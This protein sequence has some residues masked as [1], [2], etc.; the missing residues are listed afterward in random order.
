MIALLCASIAFVQS[1]SVPEDF[2]HLDIY[3]QD[4]RYQA[5]T[6]RLYAIAIAGDPHCANLV[7]PESVQNIAQKCDTFI[8]LG[9]R[10]TDALA[11]SKSLSDYKTLNVIGLPQCKPE[12]GSLWQH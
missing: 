12:R 1:G 4:Y 11:L 9:D 6:R 10:M 7:A 5:E 2:R 3:W 8:S